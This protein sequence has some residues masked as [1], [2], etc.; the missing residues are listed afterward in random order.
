MF[1]KY[2]LLVAS[3][4]LSH[5]LY[6]EDAEVDEWIVMSTENDFIEPA[7]AVLAKRL[8]PKL[9]AERINVVSINLETCAA[10]S[11]WCKEFEKDFAEQLS[12]GNILYTH[13]SS[14]SGIKIVYPLRSLFNKTLCKYQEISVLGWVGKRL[15]KPS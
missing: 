9:R 4:L 10:D 12:K 8:V 6:A 2:L 7:A 11:Y 1:G 5:T 15:C 3:I 13:T 14:S